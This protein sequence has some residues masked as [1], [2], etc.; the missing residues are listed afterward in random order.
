VGGKGGGK[1]QTVVQETRNTLPAWVDAASKGNYEQISEIT[2]RPLQQYQGE[3]IAPFSPDQQAAFGLIRQNAGANQGAINSGISAITGAAG[4]T[5]QS[6]LNADQAGY[7]NPFLQATLNPTLR[8]ID[9]QRRAAVA[10]TEDAALRAGA[11]GGSRQ[12]VADAL[13]NREA[14]TV[15]GDATANLFSQGWQQ[16][17]QGFNADANRDLQGAGLRAQAG[18]E[19][20]NAAARASDITR[21]DAQQLAAVGESQQAMDQTRLAQDEAKF[22]EARDYDLQQA[23]IRQQALGQSPYS[24]VST[25]TQTRPVYNSGG[26]ISGLIGGGAAGA[27]LASALGASGPLGWGIAG[28][29]ALGG[30]LGR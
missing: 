9:E 1:S 21:S 16:A 15:A 3:T 4:Y 8:S 7:I 10:G 17:M 27:G 22:I 30:L 20:V 29:G 6:W 14:I 25:G 28:L 19:A 12:G 2:N 23:F 11:F 24:T 13:T 5:P 18:S 26:G